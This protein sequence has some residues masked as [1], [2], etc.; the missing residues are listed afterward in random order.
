MTPPPPSQKKTS[1]NNLKIP[2]IIQ[3]FLKIQKK[4]PKLDLNYPKTIFGGIYTVKIMKWLL[5][6][7]PI[8]VFRSS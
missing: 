1:S 3:N 8:T 4:I 2:Q 5:R 7:H 6:Y